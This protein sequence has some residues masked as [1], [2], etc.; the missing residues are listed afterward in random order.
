MGLGPVAA[1][2]AGFVVLG[3][4]LAPVQ[5][6]AVAPVVAAGAGAVRSRDGARGGATTPGRAPHARRTTGASSRPPRIATTQPTSTT[7][8]ASS[9]GTE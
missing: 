7:L 2:L 1:A 8:V 6:L 9:S 3:R 5:L 4:V